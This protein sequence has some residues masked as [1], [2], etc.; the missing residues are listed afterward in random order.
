MTATRFL[1]PKEFVA[2]EIKC[3]TK[4]I[5]SFQKYLSENL[6]KIDKTAEKV[7]DPISLVLK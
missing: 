5:A 6:N 2:K 7:E 3:M 1:E 4:L